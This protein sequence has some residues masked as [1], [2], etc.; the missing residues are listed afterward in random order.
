[1][2]N[3]THKRKNNLYLALAFIL[4]IALTMVAFGAYSWLFALFVIA[5]FIIGK[6]SE[7]INSNH[8]KKV[9]VRVRDEQ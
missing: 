9:P 1:M 3:N 4:V 5:P 7:E 8:R 6:M 2:Q